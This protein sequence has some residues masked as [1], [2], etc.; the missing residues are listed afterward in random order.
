LTSYGIIGRQRIIDIRVLFR[1]ES[2]MSAEMAPK[3]AEVT[4]L[5]SAVQRVDDTP[6]NAY[7]FTGPSDG[8]SA[9]LPPLPGFD[10]THQKAEDGTVHF[11]VLRPDP[12]NPLAP[13]ITAKITAAFEQ[14]KGVT[15]QLVDPS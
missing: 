10:G 7:A 12:N 14:L 1:K 2:K 6:F 3:V 15:W 4:M 13:S 5:T 11:K 8:I 9:P